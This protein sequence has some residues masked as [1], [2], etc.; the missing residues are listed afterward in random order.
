MLASHVKLYPCLVNNLTMGY[1][2]PLSSG[3]RG[4]HYSDSLLGN[5]HF[6]YVKS[7]P[8]CGVAAATAFRLQNN[9]HTR[10]D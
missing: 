6:I 2:G 7:G 9:L 8:S 5:Y 1:A 4:D 10:L 3:Y